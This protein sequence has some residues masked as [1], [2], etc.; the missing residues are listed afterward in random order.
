MAYVI[1]QFRQLAAGIKGTGSFEF[2][3]HR[4]SHA[5]INALFP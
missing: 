4:L 1:T 3:G 2:P 5:E